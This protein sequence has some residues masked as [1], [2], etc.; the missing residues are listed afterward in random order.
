MVVATYSSLKQEK[1]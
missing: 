1:I